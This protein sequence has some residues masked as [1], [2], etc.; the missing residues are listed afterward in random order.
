MRALAFLTFFIPF[1]VHAAIGIEQ[2]GDSTTGGLTYTGSTYTSAS[3]TAPDTVY[4]DLNARF[5]QGSVIVWNRGIA[6]ACARDLVNGTHGYQTFA[7][8]LASSQA[9][10][11]T[12]N[13]GMNDGYYCNQTLDQ[14]QATMTQLVNMTKAAGKIAVLEEPNPTTNSQNPNLPAYVDRLN[15]V[16]VATGTPIVQQY[17]IMTTTPSWKMLLSD[18]IHPTTE[19]YTFKA[20][21][22]LQ[23]LTPMVQK[24]ISP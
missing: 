15:Q 10:I 16:A 22:E 9:H 3:P 23:V 8:Y 7:S 17:R 13:F 19:G 4:L 6:G 21:V 18:G 12:F 2:Y 5:G 11:I 24:L 1:F 14:Y 20:R